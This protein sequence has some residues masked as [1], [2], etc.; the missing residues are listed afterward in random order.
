MGKE[1][2]ACEPIE[3][4]RDRFR[5]SSKH[6]FTF[7]QDN[8]MVEFTLLEGL[9]VEGTV[10]WVGRFELGLQDCRGAELICFRH[11]LQGYRLLE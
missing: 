9:T 8:Q 7:H 1:S 10:S 3:S 11:A 5:I 6:L 2:K 4:P